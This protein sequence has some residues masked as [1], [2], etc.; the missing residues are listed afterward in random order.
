MAEKQKCLTIKTYSF[1][2]VLFE[3]KNNLFT[4]KLLIIC[5]GS[6]G[7]FENI[8]YNAILLIEKS[9]SALAIGYEKIGVW[10]ISLGSICVLSNGCLLPGLITLVIT[11]CSC[12]FVVQGIGSKVPD[13]S[14]KNEST[15]YIIFRKIRTFMV[16]YSIW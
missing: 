12:Y 7:N 5:S 2:N 8:K 16:I 9:I 3:T 1:H 10:G 11:A 13:S 15:N 14:R 6:D 4:T